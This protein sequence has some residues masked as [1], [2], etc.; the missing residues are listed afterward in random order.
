M[1][2][3]WSR[4]WLKLTFFTAHTWFLSCLMISYF[5]TPLLLKG[6]KNKECS[7]ILFI[8][9][10][11]IRITIEEITKKASINLLDINFHVGPIIRLLEFYIGMLLIP[12]FA[13]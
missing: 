10:S 7:L 4:Y 3:P 12:F 8:I 13:F 2:I 6:I 11:F 9:I 5:L 1:I